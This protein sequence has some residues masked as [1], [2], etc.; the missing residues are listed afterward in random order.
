[1]PP[2]HN[3][4]NDPQWPSGH[5]PGLPAGLYAILP[6]RN[7]TKET[8]AIP[9]A[10]NRNSG[11]KE[12]PEFPNISVYLFASYSLRMICFAANLLKKPLNSKPVQS[13][14]W[15][16]S[17]QLT[18]KIFIQIVIKKNQPAK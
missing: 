13:I 8:P 14:P 15:P 11:K 10:W 16:K 3:A 4:H 12:G 5:S 1:M 6:V 9:M 2:H 18:R 7:Y 17:M